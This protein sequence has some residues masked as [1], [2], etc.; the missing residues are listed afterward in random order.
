MIKVFFV[1]AL[2]LRFSYQDSHVKALI[3]NT[4]INIII[5]YNYA[6]HFDVAINNIFARNLPKSLDFEVKFEMILR[7]AFSKFFRYNR[8]FEF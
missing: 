1:K 6:Q 7:N 3:K 2:I 5:D 4:I 8:D